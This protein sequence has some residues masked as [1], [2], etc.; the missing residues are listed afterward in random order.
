[1]KKQNQNICKF[2][3][4]EAGEA[5]STSNFVYETQAEKEGKIH[6]LRNHTACLVVRGSGKLVT[7]MFEQELQPGVLFFNFEGIPFRLDNTDGL[8]Y[9]Y[10]TFRGNRAKQLFSRFCISPE[11]CV[12]KGHE[13]LLSFWQSCLSKA[14]EQ[15]LDLLSESVL[16]Y[17]FSALSPQQS[18]SEQALADLVREHIES[19]YTE[20][21]L[22]LSST[23]EALGYNAKYVSRI[24]REQVGVT[25]S[26]YIRNSRIQYAVFLMEQGITAIKNVAFL[27]GYRDPF[28]FSN[29][30]RETTG[31]SPSE[32]IEQQVR[33]SEKKTLPNQPDVSERT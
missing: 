2:V 4:R 23:A 22:T 13:G 12:F 1:M 19:H 15:N 10:I 25:F 9:M 29:V 7:E 33:K 27:V 16:L 17:T 21:T 20:S 24:F 8:E 32:F 14:N 26:D 5:I 18:G 6:I 30:F 3:T 28:Y 31:I 11:R